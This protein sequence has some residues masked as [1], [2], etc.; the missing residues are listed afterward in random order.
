MNGRQRGLSEDDL[1][2]IAR[3]T[4]V[5]RE[6]VDAQYQNFLQRHPDGKINKYVLVRQ[7]GQAM[8]VMGKGLLSGDLFSDY[9]GLSLLCLVKKLLL[10]SN[11]P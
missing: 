3:N 10:V 2:F 8:H 6:E 5:T 7:R 9:S 11:V 1:D 4:A